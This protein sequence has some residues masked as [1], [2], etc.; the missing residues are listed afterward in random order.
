MWGCGG[1]NTQPPNAI[2]KFKTKIKRLW[3]FEPT[4]SQ[5]PGKKLKNKME[6]VVGAR[7]H[8]PSANLRGDKVENLRYDVN[9]GVRSRV[10]MLWN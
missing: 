7:T 9:V 6:E 8:N 5:C 1:S 2:A 10:P 4:T 3:V